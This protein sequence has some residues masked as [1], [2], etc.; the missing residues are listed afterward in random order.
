MAMT[1]AGTAMAQQVALPRLTESDIQRLQPLSFL[2]DKSWQADSASLCSKEGGTYRIYAPNFVR[3]VTAGAKKPQLAV[4]YDVTSPTSFQI[5]EQEEINPEMVGPGHYRE[6][7]TTI[8]RVNDH[9][10]MLLD[11]TTD[12]LNEEALARGK[13]VFEGKVND[14]PSQILRSCALTEKAAS[15]LKN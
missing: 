14:R 13:V 10:I 9:E 6:R 8:Q 2:F 1:L 12:A 11:S 4:R 7:V 15:S 3:R 5:I